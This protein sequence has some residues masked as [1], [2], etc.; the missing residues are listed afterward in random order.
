MWEQPTRKGKPVAKNAKEK[1]TEGNGVS[2][3]R[4]NGFDKAMVQSFMERIGAV[5]TNIDEIMAA[6]KEECAP[7]REDIAA[8]KREAHDAGIPRMEFNAVI[9]ERRAIARVEAIREKMSEEQAD[10]FDK[11]KL[12]LG[13]LADTDLG[14]AA[15]RTAGE[16]IEGARPH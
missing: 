3:L 9:T 14:R 7:L 15:R 8:I 1:D 6:A 10:N 16:Q 2:A 4:G 12:A 5:Q 11:L 13:D